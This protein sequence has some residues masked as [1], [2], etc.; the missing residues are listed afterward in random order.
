MYLNSKAPKYYTRFGLS[1]AFGA[2]GLIVA[3]V[4]EVSYAWG[5]AK[6][7]KLLSEEDVKAKYSE[8]QLLQM[9]D[10]SPLIKYTL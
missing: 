5:N 2:S 8:E 3:L 9:G 6:K 7:A 10:K 4:L 1:L